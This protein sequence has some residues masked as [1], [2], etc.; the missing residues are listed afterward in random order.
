[1]TRKTSRRVPL[2]GLTGEHGGDAPEE[3]QNHAQ[4]VLEIVDAHRQ[5]CGEVEQD[6]EQLVGL[7]HA[8]EV[9]EQGQ[10]A[11]TG[12]GQ[13]FGHPLDQAENGGHEI[14]HDKY[15]LTDDK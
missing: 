11:R 8:E 3:L 15:L 9:L 7:L 4:H 10:V 6:V 12:D 2:A 5:Q 14:G 13:E 1:M